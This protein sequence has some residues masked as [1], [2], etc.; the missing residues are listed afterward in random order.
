MN[1]PNLSLNY[2]VIS[3]L[4][5][6][7]ALADSSI[8]HL[9]SLSLEE[10]LKVKVIGSTLTE[11]TIRTVPS[12]VSVF[13]HNEIKRMGIDTLD[14]LINLVPGF[15]SF[16]S[17]ASSI[18]DTATSRGRTVSGLAAE[19]LIL[20]DGQ[21]IDEP[22]SSGSVIAASKYPLEYIEHVEFIRG[23]G[24]SIYG[25]NAMQG[26]INIISRSN[27]NEVNISYGSFNRRKIHGLTSHSIGKL[28]VNLF[29]SFSK[30][31]GDN[32]NMEDIYNRP[33]R[34]DSDDP[35]ELANLAVK[36]HYEETQIGLQHYQF[37]VNNFFENGAPPNDV[38]QRKGEFTSISLKQSFEWPS[39][40]SWCWL[41]YH[42]TNV[43]TSFQLAP[44][45]V[46]TGNSVPDSSDAWLI[47]AGFDD[48]SEIRTQ[49]H[50]DWT[51]DDKK[52]MQFGFEF[53]H[54]DAPEVVAENNFDLTDFVN[55]SFPVRYYGE[56]RATTTIQTESQR[57]ITGIYTQYQ[58][59]ISNLTRFTLGI[60]YDRFSA[61]GDNI[62]PRLALVQ[63]LTN[64]QTLKLLYGE[65]FRAPAE[66]ELNLKNN[67]V[68]LGNTDLKPETVKTWDIIWTGQWQHVSVN[69]G[70]FE[71]HFEDSIQRSVV[72]GGAIQASNIKQDPVKGFE[73]ES[74]YEFNDRWLL[75]TTYTHLTDKPDSS[76]R[77]ADQL[78]SLMLNYQSGNWNTNIIAEYHDDREMSTGGIDSNRFKLSD[79]WNL[80]GKFQY[81]YKKEWN[82][83]LMI[84]N[85]LNDGHETPS[86]NAN[87]IEGVPNRGRELLAGVTWYF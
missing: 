50:S 75:R 69:L 51:I 61:I 13:T 67:P 40:D 46:F 29:G 41:S 63:E 17:S 55:G 52:S 38:N 2:L 78:A 1:K 60:R 65:A 70:Y 45:G 23:P 30:D 59:Q 36:F 57:D 35:R 10:L 42:Q 44:P 85:L 34:I 33:N 48:F 6:L 20:V 19:I 72:T 87:L 7:P 71:N 22:R 74:S 31:N 82:L 56:L 11:E 76:F 62:S 24:S 8:E 9:F 80:F 21:R 73:F 53:R 77:Q 83:S 49:W 15:Q 79:Y 16:R 54:I 3:I 5:T 26:V 81:N 25:S 84:K 58:H 64:R 32:F 14:E 86:F 43:T 4:I 47:N 39:I 37:N 68:V 66:N 12:A 27:V 18:T 28:E